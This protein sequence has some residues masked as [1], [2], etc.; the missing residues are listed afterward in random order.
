M[1]KERYIIIT[2]WM[3]ES[4][5]KGADLL[6][7][8]IVWDGLAHDWTYDSITKFAARFNVIIPPSIWTTAQRMREEMEGK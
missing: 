3:V 4:G 1:E 7:F 6:A 2:E 8:A 5:Y